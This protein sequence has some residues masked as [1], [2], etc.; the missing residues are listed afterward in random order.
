MKKS[1]SGTARSERHFTALLLP[2]LL[3]SNNFAGARALFERLE[4]ARIS[5]EK[6]TV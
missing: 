6:G 2:H 3:M 1:F 5:R 4:L